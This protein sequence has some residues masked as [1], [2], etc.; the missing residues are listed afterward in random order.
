MVRNSQGIWLNSQVF[1]EPAIHF[2]KYGYYTDAPKGTISWRKYWDEELRRCI[3]GHE[4]SGARITGDHYFYLNYYR[5]MKKEGNRKVEGF[6]DFWDG[7]YN[8]FHAVDIARFGISKEELKKLHL[9]WEPLWIDGGHHIM[10]AKA[11]RKGFAQPNTEPVLT[12]SGWKLMGDIKV[13]D[14]VMTPSGKPTKVL[15]VYPQGEREVFEVVLHDNR[16]TR[17]SEDHLW[18]IKTSRG[19]RVVPT[20]FFLN[21]KLIRNAGKENS[22]YAYHLPEIEPLDFEEKELP[23]DPYVLG[24]LLGDGCL[25][26]SNTAISTGDYEIVEELQNRLPS[27]NIRKQKNDFGYSIAYGLPKNPLKEK[28]RELGVCTYSY[29]K[30]VPKDYL[31]SSI[32]QRLELLRGLMDTD[33]TSS[34]CGTVRFNTSSPQLRDDVLFLFR[35]LGCRA[36]W[37]QPKPAGWAKRP[38]Y[39]VSAVCD[40]DV[41]KLD[42]KLKNIKKGRKYGYKKIGIREV[43]SLGYTEE[44]TCILVED[45][46]HLYITKDFIPTHNSY[47]NSAKAVNTYNTVRKSL[48]LFTA[49]EKKYLFPNGIMTMALNGLSFLSEHTAWGKKREYVDRQD[50][51]RASYRGKNN[52]I[53]FEKGYKSEMMALSFKDRPGAARGKDPYLVIMEE[54]GEWD[55]FLSSL[56]ATEPSTRDGSTMTGQ[57]LAFGTGGDMTS[58]SVDFAD[59]FYNP[60]LHNFLPFD[61]VW[62]EGASGNSCAFFF[63][64]NLNNPDYTDDQGNS[65]LEAAKKAEME[66]R[67]RIVERSKGAVSMAKHLSEYALSPQEAFLVDNINAFPVD[68]LQRRLN[69]LMADD[70]A[71]IGKPYILQKEDGKVLGM[72]DLQGT[73]KP[74]IHY[75]AEELD[76]SGAVV[77]YEEPIPNPPPGTYVIGYDPYRHNTSQTDSLGAAFVYKNPTNLSP[78]S[79]II[80]AEYVGRPR[81]TDEYERRLALLAEYYNA[82]IL[83][84]NEVNNTEKNFEYWNKLHLLNR[85]PD[86]LIKAHVKKSKVKREFGMHMTSSFIEAGDKY[87]TNWLLTEREK[88]KDG[89]PIYNLDLLYSIGLIEEMIKY[90]PKGNFDRL[91]AFRLV[92]FAREEEKLNNKAGQSR[93]RKVINQLLEMK[94]YSR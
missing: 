59:V 26:G 23:V 91:M 46:E 64:V 75:R 65:D 43:R 52:G 54:A 24:V 71:K 10:V 34:P 21:K 84:E 9:E 66:E 56:K 44:Q 19:D 67:Q 13:G 82:T 60:E 30:F 29:S 79:D 61:N 40:L 49:Y 55:G 80:V 3:E 25:T 81:T 37:Y 69:Q 27:A 11:R 70:K 62:D 39:V 31:Y 47:K 7:D 41:F 93:E 78:N 16:R 5:I 63:P 88:T 86:S 85:Q 6:P 94:K 42:R 1:R 57:I 17:C 90:N 32:S 68:L 77:V 35:S 8:Y 15:E 89:E 22:Y 74:I 73:L 83:Y 92:M 58:A 12:P 50:H 38:H 45:P 33:G 2:E 36:R 4:V 28:L 87:I 53:E 48:I 76:Q 20:S 72:P 51:V 14:L 18:R